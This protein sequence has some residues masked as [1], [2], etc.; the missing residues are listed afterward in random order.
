MQIDTIYEGECGTVRHADSWLHIAINAMGTLLLGASNHTMQCL[1][2]P[3]RSEVD[4]AHSNGQCLD[5]G[6]PSIKNLNGWVKKIIFTFSNLIH[7]TVTLSMELDYLHYNPKSRL[8]RLCGHTRLP[9]P[10]NSRLLP[11]YQHVLRSID[12]AVT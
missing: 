4:F 11:E 7:P 9:Q 1:S 2:S 8:Q 10:V 5:L 3:T 12:S 6:F